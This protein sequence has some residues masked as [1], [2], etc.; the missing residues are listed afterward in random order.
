MTPSEHVTTRLEAPVG[1]GRHR[2]HPLS[3]VLGLGSLAFGALLGVLLQ[4]IGL[5]LLFSVFG[6]HQIVA[7]WFRTYEVRSDELLIAEGIL[8]RHDRVIPYGRV[9]QV[10]TRQNLL[11]LV[12]GMQSLRIETAGSD[13]GRVELSLLDRGTADRLR[14]YVL[15][16]RAEIQ[17]STEA[18]SPDE[19]APPSVPAR[20]LFTLDGGRLVLAGATSDLVVT[21]VVCV[22][23]ALV[24]W[25]PL[26]AVLAVGA[27][28][29]AGSVLLAL[30]IGAGVVVLSAFSAALSYARYT[31]S[32][33]G[34]DLRVDYG[35]FSVQ[36][37]TVP[38]RRVQHVSITDNPVRR[39]LGLLAVEL[40]SAAPLGSGNAASARLSIPLVRR[41]ELPGLLVAVMQDPTWRIPALRSRPEA[42]RRRAIVRRTGGLAVL[43]LVP[44]VAAFPIGLLALVV[45]LFGIP[46]G[47]IAHARAGHAVTAE[48]TTFASGVLQYR[49]ELVPHRRVQSA[50]THESPLQR[51][52]GL[53]TLALDVAGRG[54]TPRLF[55][56]EEATARTLRRGLPRY[57][58]RMS[59]DALVA[60]VDRDLRA[61]RLGEER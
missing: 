45:S 10:D 59:D 34:T 46:W 60:P 16:R 12:L 54:R 35:L 61:R 20:L 3:V 57:S 50:R 7:W 28:W 5:E 27:G 14:A 43:A 8:T 15:A 2:T 17:D 29:L 37:V 48:M 44:A 52:T 13:A 36:H 31:L 42:A 21:A 30:A 4:G 55:D 24:L 22:A 6:L 19:S 38:R 32:T 56:M 49:V 58:P 23:L 9:Q 33:S 25:L 18:Q 11:A 26:G 47:R 41:G 53:A 40:H 51:R 39:M 1:P